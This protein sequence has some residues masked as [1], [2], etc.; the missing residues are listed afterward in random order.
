[1]VSVEN[2]DI[3]PNW[4][5]TLSKATEVPE[6]RI[7]IWATHTHTAPYIGGYWPERVR[8]VEKTEEYTRLAWETVVAAVTEAKQNPVRAGIQFGMGSCDV[9][10]NRDVIGEDPR[11]GEISY[12]TGQNYHGFSDKRVAVLRF[13]G[14]NGSPLAVVFSYGVH[15]SVLFGTRMKDGGQLVSGDLAGSAMRHAEHLLGGDVIAM[16]AMAPAADQGPRHLG[17]YMDFD[18][19]GNMQPVDYGMGAH[20][21]ADTLGRELGAEV[22]HI[23]N[24]MKDNLP[25]SQMMSGSKTIIVPGKEKNEGPGVKV[26]VSAADYIP[27][28]PVPIPI[29]LTAMGPLV[30]VGIGCESA[31]GNIPRIEQLL[32][33]KGFQHALIITQCNGSSSYMSDREGYQNFTFSAKASH[34]MPGAEELL[35]QGLSAL[36]DE[37]ISERRSCL[38]FSL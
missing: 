22:Y 21:I 16:F 28:E 27:A 34:M 1:M 26:P 14:E 5:Q 12:S 36:L 17:S 31:S 15:S 30:L 3:D 8:D 25:V 19:S 11:T 23:Y 32:R 24:T 38:A 29:S 35:L 10:V 13:V 6:N 18:L 7:M 2:G 33:E 9:N 37:I 4:I 20:A